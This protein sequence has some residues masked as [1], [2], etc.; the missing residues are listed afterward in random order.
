MVSLLSLNEELENK[1]YF[2]KKML[3]CLFANF[4]KNNKFE[5]KM[6]TV[7]PGFLASV[8]FAHIGRQSQ[9]HQ[10]KPCLYAHEF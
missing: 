9:L 1:Y 10:T 8:W 6:I 5:K 2:M 3:L 4:T 7:K